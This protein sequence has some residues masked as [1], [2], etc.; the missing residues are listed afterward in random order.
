MANEVKAYSVEWLIPQ[1]LILF[2][3]WGKVSLDE[4]LFIN[5]TFGS[6]IEAGQAPVHIIGEVGEKGSI[7]TDI[8]LL[9]RKSA[10]SS[11]KFGHLIVVG[12]NPLV[13]FIAKMVT[14]VLK[15]NVHMVNS[16]DEAKA[17]LHEKD[18]TISI[19]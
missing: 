4:S 10:L 7:P 3:L 5:D 8:S 12:A 18:S 14:S 17:L 11:E 19:L 2:R 13:R 16:L 15:T 6:M 1:R 9:T